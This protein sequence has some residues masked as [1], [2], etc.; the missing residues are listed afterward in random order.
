MVSEYYPDTDMLYIKL[1]DGKLLDGLRKA[2]LQAKLHSN[3]EVRD[4]LCRLYYE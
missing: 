2:T 4:K 3:D 1:A